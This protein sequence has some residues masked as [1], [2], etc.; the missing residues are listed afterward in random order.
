[1]VINPR[2]SLYLCI[3]DKLSVLRDQKIIRKIGRWNNQ[4]DND[5]REGA[6][7]NPSVLIQI[8][9]KIQG[10]TAS[11]FELQE[12]EVIVTCHIGIDI[13]KIDVGTKDWV[14]FQAVY[15]QLQ[16]LNVDGDGFTY[17]GL[18]RI[19]EVEDNNYDGYY[20]GRIVFSTFLRDCTSTLMKDYINGEI[21]ELDEDIE[22]DAI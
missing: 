17:T 22:R 3:A 2:Q 5:D 6:S 20:H 8:E 18:D 10:T 14:I 4:I 1:M 21:D 19:E 7:I 13:S 11:Q 15:G 16:G 12:I 9:N